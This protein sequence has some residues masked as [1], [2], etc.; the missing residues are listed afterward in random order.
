MTAPFTIRRRI[1]W[2][3]SDPAGV[4]YTPR[5]F[6]YAIET[7]EEWLI[8]ILGHDW[9][10]LQDDFKLDTPTVKMGCEFLHPLRTGDFVDITLTVKRLGGASI[11]YVIDGFNADNRHCFRVDQTSCFVNSEKFEPVRII[12]EFRTKIADYQAACEKQNKE[13]IDE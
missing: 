8:S 11:T 3:D 5:V 12:D 13:K 6:H 9:M 7:V 1:L 2:G 4:I 10:A